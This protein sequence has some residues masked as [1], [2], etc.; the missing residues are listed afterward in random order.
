MLAGAALLVS[1]VALSVA[2]WPSPARQEMPIIVAAPVVAKAPPKAT[3]PEPP[4]L[5]MADFRRMEQR[6]IRLEE[7]ASQREEMLRTAALSALEAK[8]RLIA[9]EDQLAHLRRSQDLVHAGIQEIQELLHN[10]VVQ[11]KLAV[12]TPAPVLEPEAPKESPVPVPP[13]VPVAPNPRPPG[14][15]R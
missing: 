11:S 13:A 1:F 14:N 15:T 5:S 6:L 3:K 9:V 12:P 8:D 7:S 2:L 10:H 4:P